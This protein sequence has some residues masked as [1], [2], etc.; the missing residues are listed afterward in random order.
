M[1]DKTSSHGKTSN[2]K[3]EIAFA[4]LAEIQ[5]MARAIIRLPIERLRAA[6]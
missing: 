2:K 1:R 4:D 3:R 5:A 6:Q